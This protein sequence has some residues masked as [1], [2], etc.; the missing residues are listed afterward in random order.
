MFIKKNMFYFAICILLFISGCGKKS[1]VKPTCV[2]SSNKSTVSL[3]D[4]IALKV[5]LNSKGSY[6]LEYYKDLSKTLLFTSA[7]SKGQRFPF[8]RSGVLKV[9]QMPGAITFKIDGVVKKNRK[10]DVYIDFKNFGKH[11]FMKKL[12]ICTVWFYAPYRGYTL[13]SDSRVCY[14][15]QLLFHCK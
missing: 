1:T 3:N 5:T 14:S 12:L 13:S 11:F 6:K 4:K 8:K 9:F 2:V 10:G 15:K 7:K